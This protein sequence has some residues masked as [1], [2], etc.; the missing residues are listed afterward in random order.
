MAKYRLPKPCRECYLNVTY[1]CKLKSSC[2]HSNLSLQISLSQK[3]SHCSQ[4]SFNFGAIFLHRNVTV[5]QVQNLGLVAK[6]WKCFCL[7]ALYLLL[8]SS[9]DEE[10]YALGSDANPDKF[11]DVSSCVE[12]MSICNPLFV[13]VCMKVTQIQKI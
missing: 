5:N 2:P 8:L 4:S 1:S 10:N 12:L 3:W 7:R 11:L 13:L 9:L 6:I